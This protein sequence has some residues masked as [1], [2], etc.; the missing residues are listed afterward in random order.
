MLS[1]PTQA[2]RGTP[3]REQVVLAEAVVGELGGEA[4]L[5]ESTRCVA[6]GNTCNVTIVHGA[7]ALAA[8]SN[9]PSRTYSRAKGGVAL[10]VLVTARRSR[11]LKKKKK[12]VPSEWTEDW[13]QQAEAQVPNSS[14]IA[15]RR[16]AP[17]ELMLA[18]RSPMKV[19][20][21]LGIN[22]VAPRRRP[23]PLALLPA[24]AL[25]PIASSF[26]GRL[27]RNVL[28]GHPRDAHLQPMWTSV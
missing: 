11:G 19:A 15:S 10:A 13:G 28:S 9:D 25:R 1:M 26:L 5:L 16:T 21:R 27:A 7:P 6:I 18:E 12:K 17:T 4:C 14:R 2:G 22:S 23:P 20:A 24:R 8:E 3:Q